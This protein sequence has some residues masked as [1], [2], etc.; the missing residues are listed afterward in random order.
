VRARDMSANRELSINVHVAP[1][2]GFVTSAAPPAGIWA[3]WSPLCNTLIAG[4]RDAILV[5]TT[6]TYDQVDRLAD[7]VERFGKQVAGVVITR[8][9]SDHW[10]GLA[11]LQ[12]RFPHARGLATRVGARTRATLS[13]RASSTCVTSRASPPRATPPSRPSPR[14]WNCMATG[15]THSRCG[16]P[17]KPPHDATRW[18]RAVIG[19]SWRHPGGQTR[20]ASRARQPPDVDA[21]RWRTPA[22]RNLRP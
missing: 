15:T 6:I 5:D 18:S 19:T 20:L 21:G 3:M 9:H 13:S 12:E 17:H 2:R 1:M 4:E 14:C 8:G 10:I 16:P 22:R 7:W 11:R